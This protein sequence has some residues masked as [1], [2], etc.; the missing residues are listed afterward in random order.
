MPATR[1]TGSPFGLRSSPIS[2]KS[3]SQSLRLNDVAWDRSGRWLIWGEGRSDRGVLVASTLD[4]N[5]PRDLTDEISVRAR[6]GY[7]GGDFTAGDNVVVFSANN[8]LYRLDLEGG[9]PRA[10][11]PAYAAVAAPVISPDGRW[12]MYVWS[13]ERR[14][15]VA[16]ADM[17]GK[18]WPQVVESGRDFY[19]QPRFS[20][21]G[22]WAAWVAWDHPNMPWDGTEL[23]LAR[24]IPSD[25]GPPVLKEARRIAGSTS[26]AVFQPEF[27]PDSRQLAWL[28]DEAGWHNFYMHDLQRSQT[29]QLT[30]ERSAQ[31]GM[32]AWTQ[33]QRMY[34]FRHD[35]RRIHFLR[36]ERGFTTLCT[37]DGANGK[38]SVDEMLR[39]DYSD[40]GQIACHPTEHRIA[41]IGSSGVCPTRVLVR[42]GK[43]VTI[44]KRASSESVPQKDLVAPRAV[45]WKGPRKQDVHALLYLPRG[46]GEGG[47]AAPK[48][49]AI[50][51]IHGGPTSQSRAM[52][53]GDIQF[54]VTRGYTVLDVNY[55]GSTGYGREYMDELKG[56]WGVCDV[57]D[58]IGG[59]KFLVKHGWADAKKLVIMGGSAGGYTVL[60]ALVDH[61]GFFKAGICLY[62]V[63]NQFTLVA[64]THKF[65]ERY[66]DYLL[67]PLP[68][69]A[70][71]Y[72][73]R[74]PV[75]HAERIVDPVAVFQGEIDEVVPKSQSDAIVESLK[76]RN[77]PHEYHVYAGEGHGWRKAETIEAFYKSVEAFL[78]NH[79][80]FA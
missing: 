36:N 50:I 51:R 14:D 48:P 31:L 44:V 75:F 47:K 9:K 35:S 17:E 13:Y 23:F 54:F 63:A 12:A 15:G 74:S 76:R 65:E 21:D 46:A 57:E 25:D 42:D 60:Q 79:V 4:G 3:L 43:T 78:K 19:M 68:Q 61:P 55:R 8:R 32:P 30:R 26:V 80:L 56:K 67:G 11:T 38:I 71:V 53:S 45:T 18:L 77:I 58:A 49:P 24:V 34:G 62:G 59:A 64:D 40:L 33:G 1:S 10:I 2:P 16:I 27:S 37:L 72:R 41:L 20:P 28:S 70:D 22:K 7:G 73:D 6:V 52:Y 39:K 5:A 66:S 29:R 69:A